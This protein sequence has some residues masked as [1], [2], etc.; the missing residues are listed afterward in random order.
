MEEFRKKEGYFQLIDH[1][2]EMRI[3]GENNPLFMRYVGK[4]YSSAIDRELINDRHFKKI[5]KSINRLKLSND[6]KIFMDMWI[7]RV[8]IE[9]IPKLENEMVIGHIFSQKALDM[10][11]DDMRKELLPD[12]FFLCKNI[13]V[14]R[15]RGKSDIPILCDCVQKRSHG[16]IL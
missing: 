12:P 6:M 15:G 4:I 1:V 16:R 3:L 11:T 2:R 5:C 14:A 13:V 10:A 8:Q 7:I 9:R